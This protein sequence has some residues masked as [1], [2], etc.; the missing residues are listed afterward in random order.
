MAVRGR[1][2]KPADAKRVAG[3]PGKRAL[4]KNE[5]RFSDGGLAA[6]DW[7]TPEELEEWNR[8]VPELQ[9]CNVAKGIHQGDLEGICV[10]Y[11]QWRTARSKADAKEA[12]LTYDAYRKAR[13]EFGLTP[14]SAGRVASIGANDDDDPAAEFFT[15]PRA[16]AS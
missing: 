3:N 15:G 1:K 11:G 4:P 16:V 10:L 2:P 7:F 9:V 6:P 14:A 5:P 8:I 12:R 13:N